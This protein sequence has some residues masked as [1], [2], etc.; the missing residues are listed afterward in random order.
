MYL[1]CRYYSSKIGYLLFSVFAFHCEYERALAAD[2]DYDRKVHI[3]AFGGHPD[4]CEIKMGGTAILWGDQGHHVKLVAAT[5]GDIGHWNMAGGPLAKRRAEEVQLAAKIL[6]THSVILDNHDGE[7]LPTLENRRKFTEEIRQW[8]A[9]IV[10]SHRPN[11]Y[12]PDH[13]YT[14]VLVQDTAFMVAVP[15]FC[16]DTKPLAQNPV[17]LYYYDGF[18]Q[19]DS[20]APDLVVAIDSVI[21]RKLEALS[22]MESQFY[23]GGALGNDSLVPK[24]QTG[25][26]ARQKEVR[27]QFAQRFKHTADTY[28][29]KLIELYGEE[30]GKQ[31]QYAEAFQI[32]EYG[33]QPTEAE[34]RKLFPFFE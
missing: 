4:D 3:T 7:L 18:T 31:V 14:G 28:R 34:F 27:E 22:T 30:R 2:R 1:W 26:L 17:Y 19:P 32:C 25:G 13:R 5:N 10:L 33:Y 12:H 23:E 6:G 15:F 24:N 8:N 11:D 20:F 16:P 29:D 9:D 21:E